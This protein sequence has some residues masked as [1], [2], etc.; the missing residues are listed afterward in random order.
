MRLSSPKS[1]A[2]EVITEDPTPDD[3]E[4]VMLAHASSPKLLFP[5]IT[6]VPRRIPAV[7]L[8]NG[9]GVP[10]VRTLVLE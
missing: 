3:A 4:T 2:D 10:V 1:P 7:Q 8:S 5:E 6:S 9:T